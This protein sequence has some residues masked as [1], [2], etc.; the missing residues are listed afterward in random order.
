MA[1]NNHHYGS[2]YLS[3]ERWFSFVHQ[4]ASVRDLAPVRVAEVGI[5]PGVVGDMMRATYPMCEYIGIDIDPQLQPTICADVTALPFADQSF[6][7]TFCCQVLEHLPFSEFD[8]AIIE[9]KRVTRKRLVISLPNVSPFIYLRFPGGRRLIPALWRGISLP[10]VFPLH[11]SHE[12]H[13]QHYW[14]IGKY[15]YP[16][17]RI[18]G[19]LEKYGF[20]KIR[21][22]R[23]VERNYW[24]FFLLD[25]PL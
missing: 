8:T 13:G 22:F 14:E 15:Q 4:I 2:T 18:L 11:H 25:Q 19:V 10:T 5:G 21:H 9:L 1:K 3:N 24:H 23:M 17:S 16:V 20:A 7:V 12:K 6:D